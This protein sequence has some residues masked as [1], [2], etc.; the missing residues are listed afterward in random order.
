[1]M[2]MFGGEKKIQDCAFPILRRARTGKIQQGKCSHFLSVLLAK[3]LRELCG[4][5]VSRVFL[6]SSSAWHDPGMAVIALMS[7]TGTFHCTHLHG[8]RGYCR[9]ALLSQ[10]QHTGKCSE[11]QKG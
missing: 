5:G 11:R 3:C 10:P 4:D 8:I 1:M 6:T 2:W 7:D 9:A